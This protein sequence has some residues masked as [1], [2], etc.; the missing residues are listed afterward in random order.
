M[1]KVNQP[2][3]AFDQ[4]RFEAFCRAYQLEF[5]KAFVDYLQ[6]HNDAQSQRKNQDSGLKFSANSSF[7]DHSP[8]A[9]TQ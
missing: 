8:S 3:H 1:V 5:P 4:N 6:A 2:G 9:T 7:S